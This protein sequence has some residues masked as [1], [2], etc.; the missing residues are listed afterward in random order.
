[1]SSPAT[2]QSNPKELSTEDF[3]NHPEVLDCIRQLNSEF[4]KEKRAFVV[5]DVYDDEGE[6]GEESEEWD[7]MLGGV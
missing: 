7:P 3:T 1:M 5:S 6:F 4:A 2:G